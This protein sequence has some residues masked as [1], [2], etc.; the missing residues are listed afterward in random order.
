MIRRERRPLSCRN[1][2]RMIYEKQTAR[3]Q[4]K[5][6]QDKIDQNEVSELLLIE[7]LVTVVSFVRPNED[8]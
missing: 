1:L 2:P 6:K 8:L 4:I 7:R 5:R 3:Q